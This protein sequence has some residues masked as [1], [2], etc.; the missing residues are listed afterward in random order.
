MVRRTVTLDLGK[1][2]LG[3]GRDDHERNS[4]RERE[5]GLE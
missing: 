3:T 1:R 5:A 2:G 4:I